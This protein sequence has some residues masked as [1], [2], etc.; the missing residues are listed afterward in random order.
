MTH[1]T[2][3]DA[4]P[5]SSDEENGYKVYPSRW[6]M[7]FVASMLNLTTSMNWITFAA[8]ADVSVEFYQISTFQLNLLSMCFVLITIPVGLT[9][10]WLTDTFGLRLTFMIAAW[11]NGVGSLLRNISAMDFVPLENKYS[12]VL[13]GQIL[14]ACGEKFVMM[15]P[16]KLAAIWFP[17]NQRALANMLGGITD[18]LGNM[19]AF[20]LVPQMVDVKSDI[21]LML[22]VL[23]VP[24]L[25]LTLVTTIGVRKSVP[26]TP[27]S[28]SAATV[29]KAFYPGLKKLI[30]N[31]AY[32]V[33]NLA[34]GTGFG[35]YVSI[36]VLLE[37][38][39]CPRGYSDVIIYFFVL[40]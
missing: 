35:V 4:K 28:A 31:K 13:T 7:L 25:C 1:P 40:Y 37:Q 5:S 16:T 10:A 3:Q 14:V 34:F 11:T 36:L 24:A 21:P 2:A 15:M 18:A 9:A 33:L 19:V 30:R 23:S 32:L 29:N 6:F 38:S 8:A 39:L 12:V 17:E 26:P 20:I 22:W 27:P